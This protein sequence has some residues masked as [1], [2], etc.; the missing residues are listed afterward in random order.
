MKMNNTTK[1][2]LGVA[3]GVGVAY[4]L[5]RRNRNKGASKTI[6]GASAEDLNGAVN[7]VM[8]SKLET[9]EEQIAYILE[10]TDA[11][12]SEETSGFEGVEYVWNEKLGSLY[13]KGTISVT[14]EPAF[15]TDVFFS[16]DG[17]A[18]DDP[19]D[20]A[21]EVLSSLT[22]KEV[23]LAYNL[24]KYRKNNPKG[25]SE[26]QAFIEIG[27]KDPKV[28]EV[29]KSKIKPK[30]NDVKALHKHPTWAEKW[31]IKK[32]KFASLFEKA[33]KC[34]RRP[35]NKRKED[36]WKNCL[37]S[38]NSNP[39]VNSNK[40]MMDFVRVQCGKK[41][42]GSRKEEAYKLCVRDAKRKFNQNIVQSSDVATKEKF[43]EQRQD[44]FAKQVANRRSGA[45][46]G[47]K[48]WDGRSNKFEENLVRE[49]V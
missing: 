45:M 42:I 23:Q 36:A 14:E 32:K 43:N 18:S 27:G 2:L 20:K 47:G 28:L 9:R 16:A 24:V 4:L 10:N 6:A 39:S 12:M 30:L 11:N 21:E 38:V 46:F 31:A 49:G 17:T 3:V 40:D 8:E 35:S 41:P 26:E 37:A 22:D 34:G 19:T 29:I 1:I 33:N 48:R 25:I 15:Y 44:E 7:D 5:Y 13:P